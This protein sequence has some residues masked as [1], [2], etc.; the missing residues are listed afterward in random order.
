[1]YI[2]KLNI[3]CLKIQ[4]LSKMRPSRNAMVSRNNP[5][6]KSLAPICPTC[7]FISEEDKECLLA[8]I[9][10]KT[11]TSI[12]AS[13]SSIILALPSPNVVDK[14]ECRHKHFVLPPITYS[15]AYYKVFSSSNYFTVTDP[16]S[17]TNSN[18]FPLLYLAQTIAEG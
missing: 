8:S 13:E 2:L 15:V 6:I 5:M 1:M 4:F 17:Y 7:Q 3:K 10:R 16:K 14:D 12:S 18:M 9:E 11:L